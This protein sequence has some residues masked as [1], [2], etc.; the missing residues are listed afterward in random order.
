[1]VV[2]KQIKT[3]TR[4]AGGRGTLACSC[5]V[6]TGCAFHAAL[7]Q[8]RVM[9]IALCFDLDAVP[10]FLSVSGAAKMMMKRRDEGEV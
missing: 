10:F 8:R 9:E 1:M 5:V 7:A 6:G 4:G 3:G 2:M